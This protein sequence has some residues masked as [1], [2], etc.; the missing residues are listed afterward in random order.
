MSNT[1]Q[2]LSDYSI[3]T[4]IDY[5]WVIWQRHMRS[6]TCLLIIYLK[7]NKT[8]QQNVIQL[9]LYIIQHRFQGCQSPKPVFYIVFNSYFVYRNLKLILREQCIIYCREIII[10]N[11]ICSVFIHLYVNFFFHLIAIRRVSEFC[12]HNFIHLPHNRLI[13][14]FI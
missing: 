1:T 4:W 9:F 10:R 2:N 12:T 5:K 13:K 3:F 14:L 8:E 6:M 11:I 7:L